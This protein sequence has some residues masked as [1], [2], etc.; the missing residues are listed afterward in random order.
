MKQRYRL[1]LMPAL[2]YFRAQPADIPAMSRI[3]LAVTENTL[4]DPG[5][6][7]LQMYH[8]YLQRLGRGWVCRSGRRIVGFA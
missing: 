6:V 7:T 3:R 2:T 1:R 8:D 5:K 4:S